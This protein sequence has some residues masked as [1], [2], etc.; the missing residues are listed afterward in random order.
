MN[1]HSAEEVS[2]E[3]KAAWHQMI[4]SREAERR[5]EATRRE[6]TRKKQVVLHA[7]G[8]LFWAVVSLAL[9]YYHFVRGECPE[10]RGV[11]SAVLSGICQ[12]L[13]NWA[14]TTI[15]VAFSA[16][17]IHT[18]LTGLAQVRHQRGGA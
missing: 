8:A 15:F 7:F 6:R 1:K 17:L 2:P 12:V 9:S 3:S 13:G 4:A 16:M 5:V 10:F 14:L 18:A 11:T